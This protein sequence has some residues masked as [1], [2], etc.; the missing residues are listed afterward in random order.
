ML[1]NVYIYFRF[2]GIHGFIYAYLL[3]Y[4]N[5]YIY[6]MAVWF[7]GWLVVL[8]ANI[9]LQVIFPSRA[10]MRSFA[11][12]YT[13]IRRHI[14]CGILRAKVIEY[15]IVYG[16]ERRFRSKKLFPNRLMVK[17]FQ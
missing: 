8:I 1:L 10:D 17:W 7:G 12:M 6:I 16:H 13:F 9:Y 11:E 5:T 3:I 2:G 15:C 4:I 14:I